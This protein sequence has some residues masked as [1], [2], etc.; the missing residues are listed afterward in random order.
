[1]KIK[2]SFCGNYFDDSEKVCPDCGSE[3]ASYKNAKDSKGKPKTI[4]ALKK[5]YSDRHLP[6]PNVTRFFI[7]VNCKSP[8]A[9]GIYQDKISGNF[10]VYK[11]KASGERA[12]R[13]EG[14]DEA[15]AVNEIYTKLK[16]QIIDQKKRNDALKSSVGES[17]GEKLEDAFDAVK[18]V[19]FG[20]GIGQM[21]VYLICMPILCFII[22]LV[23]AIGLF[24]FSKDPKTG[25]YKYDD[26]Y[27]Y[28]CY[29]SY[30]EDGY[31]WYRYL[32][33]EKKWSEPINIDIMPEEMRTK[34]PSKK[35]FLGL[36]WDEEYQCEDFANSIYQKDIDAGFWIKEGYFKSEDNVFY[37]FY[38]KYNTGWYSFSD[39]WTAVNIEELPEL[40]WHSSKANEFF[41]S[42]TFSDDLNVTDFSNTVFFKD[43]A[44]DNAVDRGYYHYDDSYYYHLYGDSSTGWYYYSPD[45]DWEA[46]AASE[47]PDD[48]QHASKTVDFYYT[49]T[50]NSET[51][52]TDF[53]DTG[54]YSSYIEEENRAAEEANRSYDY[55]DDDYDY[56]WDS[57]D[58][59]DSD[60]YDWDSD[61]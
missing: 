22:F 29:K 14:T 41:I 55:D 8:K 52:I 16:E 3:N 57:D 6:P 12:I 31:N 5:W 24:I 36:L 44:I 39:D 7:G 56:D 38:D 46:I 18:D 54:F 34:K 10:I 30:N 53:E 11:N 21:L 42:E 35:Y 26:S 37:H 17:V 61:W 59:W 20:T 60:S 33:D 40:L 45:E 1:M 32:D 27:Y 58:T 50:W 48:L 13:Y 25:Y 19:M 43:K 28:Y 47:L 15:Y 2:C 49:P 4:T 23:V 9:F 51:Q